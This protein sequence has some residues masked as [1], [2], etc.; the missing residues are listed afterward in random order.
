MNICSTALRLS[1]VAVF[2]ASVLAGSPEDGATVVGKAGDKSVTVE[3]VRTALAATG[4][5]GDMPMS[6]D[7]AILDQ[8]ARSI[9]VK[10]IVLQ[11][12]MG[13][14][15]EQKPTVS[16]QLDRLRESAIVESYV[17][18]LTAPPESYPSGLELKTAY[19][20]NKAAFLIPR[21]FRM[22]QIFVSGLNSADSETLGKAK[23]K[24]EVLMQRLKQPAADFAAIARAESEERE[25]AS[26]DGEIGWLVETQIQ[27]EI[28]A[29]LPTMKLNS[30]SDPVRL[31]DGWH[32]L[33]IIDIREAYTPTFDQMSARLVQQLRANKTREN[34]QAFFA[35]TVQDN[36]MTIDGAALAKVLSETSK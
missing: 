26:R 22:A 17:Q 30:I 4:S 6:K 3:D 5:L 1:T 31:D 15:W 18:S 33:K 24:I 13:K 2:T 20:T 11:E 10:K 29:K 23:V 25:S 28:R 34:A 8:L 9:M 27:P 19:D 14:K 21:S 16:A 35:K 36:P 32:I 7:P 12:A